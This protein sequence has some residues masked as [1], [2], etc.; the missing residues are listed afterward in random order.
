MK[1]I[2]ATSW[3]SNAHIRFSF[4]YRSIGD[5]GPGVK[6]E[7]S[8]T[9]E[10]LV[11]PEALRSI[12]IHAP[13]KA[14]AGAHVETL[15]QPGRRVLWVKGSRVQYTESKA[16]IESAAGFDRGLNFMG[17]FLDG[18]FTD[19]IYH[20]LTF[21]V[22][23]ANGRVDPN[24]RDEKIGD[25]NCR[26]VSVLGDGWVLQVWIVPE[27][28]HNFARYRF[29]SKETAGSTRKAFRVDVDDVRFEAQP[30]GKW[31]VKSGRI[32]NLVTDPEHGERGNEVVVDRTFI[33]LSPDFKVL[34]AFEPIPIPDGEP[35]ILEEADEKGKRLPPS[36]IR[37]MWKD[38]GLA[39]AYDPKVVEEIREGLK[40]GT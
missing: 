10:I 6:E 23:I 32:R 1:A 36:G 8:G 13:D 40:T 19:Q 17:W 20:P 26:V 37:L 39:P 4:V 16:V 2:D 21:E 31:V 24:I 29:V 34:G 7:G 30:D 18:A 22:A 14:G 5:F 9:G 15:V 38:G 11:S 3:T 35:A 12:R 25:M 33:D 28:D 27:R